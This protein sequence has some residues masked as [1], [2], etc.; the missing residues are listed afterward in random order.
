MVFENLLDWYKRVYLWR[1][2]RYRNPRRYWDIRW[3]LRL[4][5]A[6]VDY[7][8]LFQKALKA[9]QE[10]GCENVLEIGCGRYPLKNLPGYMALDFSA[11]ALQQSGL[12]SFICADITEKI[13]LPDKSVDAIYISAVLLH[14]SHEKIGRAVSEVERVA[15]KVIMLNENR[16][17]F[18]SRFDCYCHDYDGLFKGYPGAVVHIGDV[19]A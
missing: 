12:K 13:P 14:I 17:P 2:V 7:D 18:E 11:V 16:T 5:P 4:I 3:N 9:M 15:K 6:N 8:M 1:V 19:E 10:H